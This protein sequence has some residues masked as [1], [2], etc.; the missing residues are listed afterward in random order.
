MN[1]STDRRLTVEAGPAGFEAWIRPD[2]E[3]T[4]WQ[5]LAAKQ[6]RCEPQDCEKRLEDA[7]Y[8]TP[9]LFDEN[10]VTVLLRPEYTQLIPAELADDADEIMSRF[11]LSK[12]KE[13]FCDKIPGIDDYLL[14][15]TLPSGM[16]GFLHRCFATED[17]RHA[18]TP[19]LGRLAPSARSEGGEILWADLH[20]Q[21]VDTVA[22][23]DGSLRLAASRSFR[24]PED[25]AYALLSAWRGQGFDARKG[26]IRVSGD[27]QTRRAV[28]PVLRRFVSYVSVAVV[29]TRVKEICRAGVSLASAL[30]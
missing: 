30:S 16:N 12:G 24:E 22:F 25:A 3:G 9:E 5:K 21:N 4:A 27:E 11:D 18:L 17:F 19:L 26:E 28:V 8:D 2:G 20:G 29:P 13:T 14:A 10:R 15:Y 7:V 1:E 23:A 6:W